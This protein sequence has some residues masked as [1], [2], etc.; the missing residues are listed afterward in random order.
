MQ[1]REILFRGKNV[2]QFQLW[3]KNT[4]PKT[5]TVL[6]LGDYDCEVIGHNIR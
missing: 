4:I 6:N 2:A 3:Q 1:E 5:T